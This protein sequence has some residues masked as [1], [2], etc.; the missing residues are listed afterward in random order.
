MAAATSYATHA[1]ASP[2][3]QW[4]ILA[5]LSLSVS[6]TAL[7]AGTGFSENPKLICCKIYISESRNKS[8]LDEIDKAARNDPENV[9][10]LSKFGD[11][12]YNRVRYTLVSYISTSEWIYSN[13]G[14]ISKLTLNVSSPI[15]GVLLEMVKAAISSTL[16]LDS[17]QGEHPRIGIIDDLSFHPL[18]DAKMEDAVYLA[19]DVASDI[20]SS[21]VPVFLYYEAHPQRKTLSDVRR[22]LG[23]YKKNGTAGQRSGV[24]ELNT[25]EGNEPDVVFQKNKP[26]VCP[27]VVDQ[28]ILQ[29]KGITTV[30]AMHFVEGYNVPVRSENFKKVEDIVKRL[31]EQLGGRGG[32]GPPKFLA[33]AL[34]HG[35]FV[36]VGCLLD[37]N[38]LRADQVQDKVKQIAAEQGLE[39][40]VE[41]GYYTDITKD[42]IL[43]HL[44]KIL[45]ENRIL[46]VCQS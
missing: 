42:M 25:T 14:D 12:I 20:A 9:V 30:G 17:H 11:H 15:K 27:A 45:Y 2:A 5:L 43:L 7:P 22:D 18:G 16:S 10:V 40:K 37:P 28:Q 46:G 13:E 1:M 3:G 31:R 39:D 21:K 19:K 29:K 44:S 35:S 32:E 38:Y 36:E 6:L 41:K 24:M 34:R 33:L 4:A 26:D 23:Y 8:A